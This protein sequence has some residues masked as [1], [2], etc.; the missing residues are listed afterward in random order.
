MV[1]SAG[2]AVRAAVALGALFLLSGCALTPS[3]ERAAAFGTAA[4]SVSTIMVT[5]AQTEV[6]LRSARNTEAAVCDYLQTGRIAL[7][8]SPIPEPSP[9][10]GSQLS[11]LRQVVAYSSALAAATSPEGVAK[12]KT[13][14]AGLGTASVALIN[15]QLPAPSTVAGPISTLV[16]DIGL[17]LIELE[18]RRQ[19]RAVVEETA[20]VL[21]ATSERLL[22][23]VDAARAVLNGAYVDWER[24]KTCTLTAIRR[25]PNTSGLE[26]Y[27]EY[28]AADTQARA[29]LAKLTAYDRLETGLSALLLAHAALLKTDFDF[30][31]ALQDLLRWA[32]EIDAVVDA[33]Q[34][35]A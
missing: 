23:D 4:Q 16:Q 31:K 22:D 2:V 24:A 12:L 28:I 8:A 20:P 18:L 7:A 29:Y 1:V 34:A 32:Q 26:M 35:N 14:A 15:S 5:A 9:L 11:L 13:A 19:I 25:H 10:I 33:I 21:I 3:T 30:A 17:T 6:D 27:R